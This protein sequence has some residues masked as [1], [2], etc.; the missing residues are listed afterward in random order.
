MENMNY[1]IEQAKLCKTD[2]PVGCVITHNGQIIAKT[3]NLREKN[4]D[5]TAHAE[6][7]AIQKAQIKLNTFRLKDCKMYVTLE[8]CPMCG[9]AI[10]QSGINT[11]YFG[12]YNPQYGSMGSA[13]DLPHLANSKIK[14]YGGIKE[15]ICNKILEEFFKGIR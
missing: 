2:I 1:A 12:S 10:I 4:N 5:I 9:W 13:L 7:L 15:D 3:H 6:I 11:L 14:I 8:P